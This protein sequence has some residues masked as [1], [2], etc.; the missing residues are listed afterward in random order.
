[1]R[2]TLLLLFS[3]L[4]TGILFADN[5]PVEKAQ[6]V[7]ESFFQTNHPQRM[8]APNLRMVWDGE[9]PSTRA[10]GAAPAYYVFNNPDGKGF[11]IVAG[12]D[13]AQPILGYS[14]ENSFN[15]ENMPPNLKGWMEGLHEEINGARRNGM[16]RSTETNRQWASTRAGEVV[17]QLETAKWSQDSPYNNQCPVING[18]NALTGCCATATAIVMRYH[19][20]P[21][22]GVGVIKGYKSPTENLIL[23]DRTLGHSF[24][25]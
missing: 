5:V 2:H 9:S 10:Q 19:Q 12:D 13:I 14:F 18:E 11:V 1:M 8:S 23:P 3:L 20:W 25:R 21:D 15:Q 4:W 7:A 24:S 16:T 17:V 22:C 6:A